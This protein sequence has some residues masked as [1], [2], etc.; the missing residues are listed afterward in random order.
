MPLRVD[1]SR[2]LLLLAGDLIGVSMRVEALLV[3]GTGALQDGVDFVAEGPHNVGSPPH[4]SPPRGRRDD[5]PQGHGIGG[6]GVE[7][8]GDELSVGL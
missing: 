8:Q 7:G 4:K 2:F 1:G 3:E 6:F 5:P